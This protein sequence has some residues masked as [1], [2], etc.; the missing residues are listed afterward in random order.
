[1]SISPVADRVSVEDCDTE[2]EDRLTIVDEEDIGTEAY[3]WTEFDDFG[4][5]V[6]AQAPK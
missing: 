6:I 4:F 5:T 3:Q 1:M 2:V